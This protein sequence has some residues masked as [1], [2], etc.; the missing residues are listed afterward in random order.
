MRVVVLTAMV[1]ELRPVAAALG[2]T[3]DGHRA[4]GRFGGHDVAAE[5]TA[6]GT[7]AATHTAGRV[8]A[9]GPVDRLYVVGIAGAVGD[10][11]RVGDLVEPAEVE[12]HATG[13]VL[14]PEPLP[15][16]AP[17]GRLLTTDRLLNDPDQLGPLA[18]RGVVA[19]DMETAAIG[20]CCEEVGVPWT[21]IRTISDRAGDPRTDAAVL[22]L[23]GPDGSARP[24]AALRYVAGH[25]HRIPHLAR[26]ARGTRV[27]TDRAAAELRRV[28]S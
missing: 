1:Q 26:L 9:A 21:A 13:R 23:S 3:I 4:E 15:G 28:L 16:T 20:A 2:L 5:A 19:V 10:R 12:L 7:E 11:L 27:A 18:R 25:P 17:E 24:A 14:V 22:A 8:L 6:M